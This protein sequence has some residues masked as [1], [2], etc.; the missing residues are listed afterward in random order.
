QDE[1]REIIEKIHKDLRQSKEGDKIILPRS[2]TKAEATVLEI[3]ERSIT[4][5]GYDVGIRTL[6]FGLEKDYK[7][8]R[9]P[10]LIGLFK[11]FS[12]SVAGETDY[13]KTQYGKSDYKIYGYNSF[14]ITGTTDFD[15]PWLDIMQ[16]REVANRR[17]IVEQYRRRSFFYGPYIRTAMV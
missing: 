7:G 6:Y 10:G 8:Y 16:I 15:D 1:G 12:A 5:L 2:P 14:K 4:K 17:K 11:N 9:V 13:M 3:I